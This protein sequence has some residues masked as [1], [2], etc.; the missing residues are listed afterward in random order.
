MGKKIELYRFRTMGAFRKLWLLSLTLQYAARLHTKVAFGHC[1]RQ[2][3]GTRMEEGKGSLPQKPL[4][5]WKKVE[6]EKNYL[7]F[8]IKLAQPKIR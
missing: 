2:H 5:N 3:L 4:A 6:G 8:I 7:F 1:F